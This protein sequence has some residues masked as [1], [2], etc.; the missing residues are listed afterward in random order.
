MI[1]ISTESAPTAPVVREWQMS[2]SMVSGSVLLA[3]LHTRRQ[4]TLLRW[5]GDV[6]HAALI[7]S[8][9]VTNAV[10]HARKNEELM[11]LRL[12][13]LEDGGLLIDVSDPVR[14]FPV[15][16]ITSNSSGTKEGEGHGLQVVTALCISLWCFLRHNGGKTIRAQLSG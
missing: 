8:E 5:T 7:V 15:L 1:V 12:A 14:D 2:Y 10:Q 11:E 3:R 16:D 6:D 9:L 4:L 13:V